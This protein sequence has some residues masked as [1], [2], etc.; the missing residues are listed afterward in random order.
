MQVYVKTPIQCGQQDIE[1]KIMYHYVY[2]ITEQ[3]TNKKYIGLRSC[4]ILPQDDLG[5]TYISS[6]SDMSF[7]NNQK[8]YPN[9][10]SY[11]VL[12]IHKFRFTAALEEIRLHNLYDVSQSNEYFNFV[13]ST[14]K[15]FDPTGMVQTK[16]KNNNRFYVSICDPR[17]LSGELFHVTKGLISA[18]DQYGSTM[19]VSNDDP[20]YL[21]GEL[22]GVTKGYV[23][24]KWKD[25]MDEKGFIVSI[26]DDRYLSGELISANTG[27]ILTDDQRNSL[28]KAM[29]GVPKS[30]SH[31]KASLTGLIKFHMSN[32][33]CKRIELNSKYYT[34]VYADTRLKLSRSALITPCARIIQLSTHIHHFNNNYARVRIDGILYASIK[35]GA[36]ANN[37]SVNTVKRRCISQDIVWS[38]WQYIK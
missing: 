8:V 38:S 1:I 11:E 24:V 3:H 5:N 36:L 23:S 25:R 26:K 18:K 6:S 16:D 4:N 33:D 27:Y 29:T 28:I 12:S 32:R 19:S 15:S 37:V 7:I 13:K 35:C 9:N 31:K 10:F 14:I 22:V 20:R 2:C 17:Y 34:Y 21:S 30:E